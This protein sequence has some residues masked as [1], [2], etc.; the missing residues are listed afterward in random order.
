MPQLPKQLFQVLVYDSYNMLLL[1]HGNVAGVCVS[2]C[3]VR[4]FA[5]R[6]R[7]QFIYASPRGLAVVN[8]SAGAGRLPQPLWRTAV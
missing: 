8:V 5:T 1:N 2:V 3:V 7:F 6:T 4:A